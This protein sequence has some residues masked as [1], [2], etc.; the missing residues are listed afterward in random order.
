MMSSVAGQAAQAWSYISRTASEK[1]RPGT[2]EFAVTFYAIAAYW[3]LAGVYELVAYLRIPAIETYRIH[4]LEEEK[5]KNRK[6]RRH[7]ILR[8]LTQ[9]AVQAALASAFVLVDPGNCEALGTQTLTKR[10]TGLLMAMLVLDAWQYFIHRAAHESKFLYRTIHSTHHKLYI[11]YAVGAL[12]N[13][14]LEALFLDSVGGLLAMVASGI[15]CQT[16]VYFTTFATMKTVFDHCGYFFPVNVRGSRGSGSAG[17]PAPVG[18]RRRW[19]APRAC[20]PRAPGDRRARDA[21][22]SAAIALPLATRGAA[23]VAP[24]LKPTAAC[25]SGAKANGR[26]PAAACLPPV[27]QQQPVPRRAPR[28]ARHQEQ[29]QPAVLH[30]LGP[31]AGH[32]RR[33]CQV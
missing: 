14:P 12:Y 1:L 20:A 8:V 18:R 31:A 28:R 25:C 16:S 29:L 4:T 24:A 6:S 2:P 33:P 15:D 7:V 3:A 30:L 27:Q 5:K 9:H 10:A 32:L 11:P 21:R 22:A 23:L 19:L 17:G 26:L 13:H